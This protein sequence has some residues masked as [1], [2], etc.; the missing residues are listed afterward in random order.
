MQETHVHDENSFNPIS[1][2]VDEPCDSQ[3][4]LSEDYPLSDLFN[5]VPSVSSI[6]QSKIQTVA[7]VLMA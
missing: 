2:L 1:E 7:P 3:D 6:Q 4:S 5:D